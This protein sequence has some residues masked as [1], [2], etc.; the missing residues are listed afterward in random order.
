MFKLRI[1]IKYM[2]INSKIKNKQLMLKY[3]AAAFE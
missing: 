1:K 2:K 3:N